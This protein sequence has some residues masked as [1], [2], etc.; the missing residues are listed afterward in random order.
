MWQHYKV[1]YS[2]N[3][4]SIFQILERWVAYN[5]KFTSWRALIME[6]HINDTVLMNCALTVKLMGDNSIQRKKIL[7]SFF[8]FLLLYAMIAYNAEEM[9][10]TLFLALNHI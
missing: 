8:L 10:T 5:G 4:K 7:K 2:V 6:S 3:P 9:N 1:E